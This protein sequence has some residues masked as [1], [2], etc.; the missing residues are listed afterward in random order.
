[1]KLATFGK[2]LDI[3]YHFLVVSS[4]FLLYM[5]WL[6]Y[7]FTLSLNKPL[8]NWDIFATFLSINSYQCGNCQFSLSNF[9]RSRIFF[10]ILSQNNQTAGH[11]MLIKVNCLAKKLKKKKKKKLKLIS[12]FF[13]LF[14]YFFCRGT[15]L[16]RF[17]NSIKKCSTN[18]SQRFDSN[19]WLDLWRLNKP[20]RRRKANTLG[21]ANM[22]AFLLHLLVHLQIAVHSGHVTYS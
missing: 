6:F 3:L 2:P 10:L 4:F 14:I 13:L 15:K 22:L 8:K 7:A 1:M 16:A 12:S 19:I 20:S 5:L 9:L 11:K 21:T 18:L 17:I